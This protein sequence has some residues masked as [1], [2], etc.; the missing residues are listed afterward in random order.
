MKTGTVKAGTEEEFFR[1]GKQIAKLADK[2][3]PIPEEKIMSFEDPADM[4]KLLTPAR[5][6]LF[7]VVKSH[8]G[9]IQEVATLLNRDRSAVSRDVSAME[10]AGLFSVKSVSQPGH[11]IKKEV[12]AAALK[13]RLEAQ[14]G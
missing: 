13:I 6:A 10:K 1:R 12:R 2:G 3:F 8:P 9:S 7:E 5:M 4:L 14:F 11:G